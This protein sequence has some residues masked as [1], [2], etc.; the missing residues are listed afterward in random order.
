M[1]GAVQRA[2]EELSAGRPERAVELLRRHVAVKPRD[3]EAW[4]VL[5]R[6]QLAM[7]EL[8]M[9]GASA[10]RAAGLMPDRPEPQ[11]AI[12]AALMAQG[13]D[14]RADAAFERAAAISPGDS[15][16]WRAWGEALVRAFRQGDAAAVLRRGLESAGDEPALLLSYCYALNVAGGVSP[17]EERAWHERLA[18][19]WCTGVVPAARDSFANTREP[20]RPLRI[21]W[22]SS[23][24]RE[25]SCGY[26]L[27]G[28]LS[29]M[30]GSGALTYLYSTTRDPDVFSE[31]FRALGLWRECGGLTPEGLA[32]LAREDAIDV[33]VECNG[34]TTP[35][36]MPALARRLAPVQMTY[37]G[38]PHTT[39][40]ETIDA[41]IVDERTDP[42]G[43][44]GASREVLAR[45]P[46]CFVCFRPEAAWPEPDATAWIRG[47][48]AGPTFGSFNNAAKIAPGVIAAWADVLR[49]VEGSTLLLKSGGLGGR[50]G[51][52]LRAR[53]AAAGVEPARVTVAPFAPTTRE[54]VAAY[55]RVDVAL[56]PFPYHGTTTTCE[57]LWMGVP[58][59]TLEGD[60]H[61]SRVG[62]SLLHAAG[63]GAWIARDVAG[64]VELAAGLASDREG[65]A[66]ERRELRGQ[67]AAAR[68]AWRRWCAGVPR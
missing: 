33:L 1:S 2:W 55:G 50:A 41:R 40:L 68:E 8:A 10:E 54:H 15:A 29:K 44:E 25:H 38:Y 49:R 11:A 5:A 7:G 67:A 24:F 47:E 31:R 61:R 57:A 21:A 34:W 65:L 30:E 58:V 23:D 6:A 36:H 53:F 52:V 62:V 13:E 9:S 12:G 26:F 56:D 45:V 22:L 3:A 17:G 28:P 35:T 43:S 59:V 4:L 19:A 64:Y 32:A 39:G 46:G 60:R 14:V 48:A 18:R 66:R 63:R 16:A 20:E 27:E 51:G 37:L 42:E